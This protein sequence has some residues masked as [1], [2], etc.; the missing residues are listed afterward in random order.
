MACMVFGSFTNS[1]LASTRVVTGNVREESRT[2]TQFNGGSILFPTIQEGN[3]PQVLNGPN[4]MIGS[5]NPLLAQSSGVKVSG[6]HTEVRTIKM[7]GIHGATTVIAPNIMAPAVKVTRPSVTQ[8]NNYGKRLVK[9]AQDQVERAFENFFSK[10]E[11]KASLFKKSHAKLVR[12]RNQSWRLSTPTMEIAEERQAA[13]DR[14]RQER[15]AFLAGR[16]NPE[17]VVGGYVDIRDRT[18]RGEQISFK[19]P[20]WK[21]T[22]KTPRVVKKQPRFVVANAFKVERALLRSLQHTNVRVEFIGNKKQRLHAQY[23]QADNGGRYAKIALPHERRGTRLRVEIKPEIWGPTLQRLAGAVRY[24]K[25]IHDS[26]VTH[27]WSGIVMDQRQPLIHKI[28]R[29]SIFV[30]RGRL[31]GKLVSACDNFLWDNALRIVQY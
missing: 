5:Y 14:E 9:Q 31:G 19:G 7:V 1:H 17:D 27:G 2:T 29:S 21:R 22:P 16:Y 28:S 4:F 30:I 26:E 11:M 6:A 23:V 25:E 12:G 20:F 10:P 24:V 15:E 3:K 8:I 13:L 18:K